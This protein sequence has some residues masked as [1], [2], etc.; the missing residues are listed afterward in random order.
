SLSN[1]KTA[2][3]TFTSNE[4]GS[5]FK[6]SLDGGSFSTC[7][8]PKTFTWRA[9]GSHTFKVEAIDPAGNTGTPVASTWVIDATKPTVTITSGPSNPTTQTTATFTFTASESV[10]F[11][12]Q[13]D[14]G[15]PATCTSPKTYTGL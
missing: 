3:F 7:T 15:T 5:T 14:S 2:T 4:Q 8:T 12:C 6:C 13:M 1:S 10:T 9:D 11:T